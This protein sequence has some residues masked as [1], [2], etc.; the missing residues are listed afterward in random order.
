[1]KVSFVHLFLIDILLTK[2]FNFLGLF[3]NLDLEEDLPSEDE[4]DDPDWKPS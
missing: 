3:Q 1:M 4:S 2:L